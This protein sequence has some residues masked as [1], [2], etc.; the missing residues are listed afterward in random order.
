MNLPS[1]GCPGE[2][3]LVTVQKMPSL[4]CENKGAA[5]LRIAELKAI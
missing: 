3:W 5:L 1:R 4:Y 2:A